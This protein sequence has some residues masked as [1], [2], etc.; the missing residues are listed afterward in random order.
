MAGGMG[1]VE[2]A[3]REQRRQPRGARKGP[4]GRKTSTTQL[5]SVTVLLIVL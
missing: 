3:W 4:K 1:C 5:I 2:A